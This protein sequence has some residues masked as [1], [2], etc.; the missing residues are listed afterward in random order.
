MIDNLRDWYRV[1]PGYWYT[2]KLFGFGVV[3]VTVAGW[4]LV[5]GYV[6]AMVAAM[7]ALPG[8]LLRIA[9]GAPLTIAFVWLTWVKTDGSWRWRWGLPAER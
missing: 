9:V 4:A 3:P 6:A 5:L 7:A 1:Q 8:D 2:P